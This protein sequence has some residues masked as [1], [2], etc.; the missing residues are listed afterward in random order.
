[1]RGR[2][3]PLFIS[4]LDKNKIKE[5]IAER[6]KEINSNIYLIEL[7]ISNGNNINVEIDKVDGY[8]SIKEC[9]SISRNV[10]HNLDRDMED[11]ALNVSSAGLDKPFR[12]L[13]QYK[14]NEGK[15]VKIKTFDQKEYEG[16][17]SKINSS[18]I[19]LEVSKKVREK[20]KNVMVTENI[21]LSFDQI[22]ETK[23]IISFN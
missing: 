8:V 1:M 21:N 20:K 23:I 13:N 9:M 10:E 14:K 18:D 7:Q 11:F 12:H 15:K 6:I 2:E 19:T 17:L 3:S 5:L 4:M 22:K 16:I